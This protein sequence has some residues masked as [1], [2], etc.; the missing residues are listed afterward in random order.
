MYRTRV[1]FVACIVCVNL[2]GCSQ[3]PSDKVARNL[4]LNYL[5]GMVP[6][7]TETEIAVIKS[8]EKD[9][10]LTVTI[11]AGGMTCDMPVTK[12]KKGW[13]ARG[14][15]CTGQFEAPEKAAERKR[16]YMLASMKQSIDGLNKK[17]PTMSADGT[18]RTDNY[19]LVDAS[20][21]VHQTNLAAK[22]GDMTP[23]DI[24]GMKAAFLATSC[25]KMKELVANGIRYEY[26]VNDKDGNLLV[27]HLVNSETC[28]SIGSG[29]GKP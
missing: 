13:V 4:A 6:G 7:I 29:A 21:I 14:V 25:V 12:G 24:D 16:S 27:K 2:L 8:V 3:G 22:A 5:S 17:V 9:G 10:Y 15:T 23:R 20:M 26:V 19:E 11:Q 18:L 28:S 1:F